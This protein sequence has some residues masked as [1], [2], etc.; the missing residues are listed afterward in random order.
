[1]GKPMTVG[2]D[3]AAERLQAFC[4]ELR[5]LRREAGNPTL[6]TL[7]RLM[8]GGPG[9]S[10]LSD[11]LNA[12]IRRSPRWELVAEFVRACVGHASDNGRALPAGLADLD[13]WRGRH[14][15]LEL[16]LEE[17]DRARRH[18]RQ[19]AQLRAG[20]SGTTDADDGNAGIPPAPMGLPP[21]VVGFAGR[22]LQLAALLE[23]LDTSA[24]GREPAQVAVSGI[25]GVGKTALAV[26]AAHEAWARGWFPGGVLFVE[27]HGYDPPRRVPTMLALERLLRAVGVV[28]TDLPRSQD[29]RSRL[30]RSRLVELAAQDR[31][32]LLVIDAAATAAQVVPLL[33]ATGGHRVVVT[34]QHTLA[35]LPGARLLEIGVLTPAAALALVAQAL[36]VADPGDDRVATD[37]DAAG[38]LVELC[39]FLPLALRITAA[40]L[41]AEPDQQLSEL[42]RVLSDERHRLDG[43]HFSG[44]LSLR[45]V[46]D[47]SYRHLDVDLAR[48]F[49]LL[50]LNPGPEIGAE[51]AAALTGLPDRQIAESLRR[52]RVAHLLQ[53]GNLR[54]RFHY[55]DLLRLYAVER[56]EAEDSTADRNQA[57]GRLLDHYTR[58]TAAARACLTFVDGW[59]QSRF[60]GRRD[61][62]AWLDAEH[63]N[64]VGSVGLADATGRSLLAVGLAE[65][66]TVYFERRGHWGDWTATQ[67]LALDAT[68]RLGRRDSEAVVLINL[69][70]AHGYAERLE[71]AVDCYEQALAIGRDLDLVAVQSHAL[72]A[73]GVSYR[74][75]GRFEESI[76]RY[77]QALG[78]FRSVGDLTGQGST[79]CNLA[80]A[81]TD[82]GRSQDAIPCLQQALR[83]FREI[84]YR[85]GEAAALDI[86]GIV[87]ARL[88]RFDK[89]VHRAKQA[90]KLYQRL[91]D[92]SEEA[93]VL[94]HL[95]RAYLGVDRFEEAAG[96]YEQALEVYRRDGHQLAAEAATRAWLAQVYLRMERVVEARRE[97]E[98]AKLA[99]ESS[100]RFSDAKA[101]GV[102][103]DALEDRQ[104]RTG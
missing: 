77:Q 33:P 36:R 70:N 16:A 64:L 62:L 28:R 1:M 5:K 78:V 10:T 21:D 45:A 58:T 82:A 57:T 102:E 89:A 59:T 101:V 17:L 26:R 49:R 4:R 81:H 99:F 94:H 74:L 25:P 39:G 97:F 30:F 79:L 24:G 69:G 18:N 42:M 35:E 85:Y 51:A 67:Q 7:R 93:A 76:A 53:P 90:L 20:G 61:A 55:H 40:L 72:V 19:H 100:G 29:E 84:G 31:P 91:G 27:L 11:L 2:A 34:T 3:P 68:R 96:C 14:G 37:K 48:V 13:S 103:L 87:Y 50:A 41:A 46:F 43:L 73:L 54:G 86:L 8:P 12:K 56:V 47:L 95:A 92:P 75:L 65:L 32:M 44:D 6:E 52:L 88:G 15:R 38:T 23:L 9:V 80:N 66:L 22:E 104:P 60:A 63:A 71:Q 83:I 98:E